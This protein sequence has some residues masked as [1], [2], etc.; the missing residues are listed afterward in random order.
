MKQVSEKVKDE[1]LQALQKLLLEQQNT[2]N[3]A[4]IGK[5]MDVLFEKLGR[6]PRQFVGRSPWLHP[7]HVEGE[8][9]IGGI[10]P[11]RILA[12]TANSLKGALA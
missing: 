9:L 7:V 4:A 2:F 10:L 8:E 3:D 12:R 1:R 11:V 5:T 6:G